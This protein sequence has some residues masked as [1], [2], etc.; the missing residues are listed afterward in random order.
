MTP[1][2]HAID[3]PVFAVGVTL[4]VL[5]SL[6]SV[7]AFV[8]RPVAKW[9][10]AASAATQPLSFTYLLVFLAF[11]GVI[12]SVFSAAAMVVRMLPFGRVRQVYRRPYPAVQRRTELISAPIIL[13]FDAAFVIAV[14]FSAA[15]RFELFAGFGATVAVIAVLYAWFEVWFYVTHRLIHT[16]P[17]WFIHKHHHVS[18][19]PHPLTALS[20]SLSERAI[21]DLGISLGAA[22][23]SWFRPVP[24]VSLLAF[25]T[26]TYLFNALVHCNFEVVPAWLVRSPAGKILGS[27]SFHAMHHARGRNHYGFTSSVLDYA[28]GT[29]WPDYARVH[30][31]AVGGHGLRALSERVEDADGYVAAAYSGQRAQ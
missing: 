8:A 20:F 6:A 18:S 10:D 26:V 21:Y 1:K 29:V 24:V 19:V 25:L 17:L 22:A 4:L 16:R 13:L 3:V 7:A 15:L 14:V 31:R 5:G 11:F 27:V 23:V 9:I 2:R 30:A 12:G 28:F